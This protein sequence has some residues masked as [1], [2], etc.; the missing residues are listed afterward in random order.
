MT[1]R[2]R[3]AHAALNVAIHGITVA[4]TTTAFAETTN[5]VNNLPAQVITATRSER[6][7]SEAP[8]AIS[9]LDEQTIAEANVSNTPD[10]F[11]YTESVYI[12]KT[13]LGGGSPF[14][15]GLTG[16]QVLILID[17]VRLN[18]SFFRFGPNQYLNTIDP[19]LIERIEV[20][21]G[22]TSVLYGSDALGGT[23]NIIT[24]KRRDFTQPRDAD[25]LLATHFESAAEAGT[26]RAQAE[27][28]WNQLGVLVGATGKLYGDLRGGDGVGTQIP[29]AYDEVDADFKLNYRLSERDE[30]IVAQQYARQFDVPITSE[31]T[32]G[33]SLK[34]DYEPQ[35]RRLTYLEY[36]SAEG[37]IFDRLKLNLAYNLQREGRRTIERSTPTLQ[38]RDLTEVGT[39]SATLQLE[40]FFTDRHHFTYGF[41]YY[42][43]AYNTAAS[44]V[45]LASGASTPAA[46]LT[47]DGIEY[48]SW[49]VYL[50]D[51]LQLS[52]KLDAILG[53]RY[54]DITA[55]GSVAN[56]QL[57]FETNAVVGNVN[58]LYRLGPA[59]RLAGSLAWGFRAPSIEDFFGRVDFFR[60]IPNT[61]LQPEE[62]FSKEIGLKYDNG[63]WRGELFYFHSD[64]EGFI[65]RVTVGNQPN[66]TP[67]LQRRNTGESLIQGVEL[68]FRY[69]FTPR[70]LLAGGF[71]WTEGFSRD[72]GQ[73]LRRIPPLNGNL[74]LRY[75]PHANLW[76]EAGSTL[77]TEQ[78]RLSRGDITDPRIG[79]NGT[80]G[81]AVFDLRAGYQPLAKHQ[82][83]VS[84]ENLGD[85]RYRTHGSGIF[86]P[87]INLGLTYSI[88]F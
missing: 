13:N 1:G 44:R 28:N 65:E 9:L 67:I 80:P 50:Q 75:T 33:S 15:R 22:P 82:L 20:V 70:W 87:G 40:N 23:I 58:L 72:T 6:T 37:K 3:I 43:D 16:E 68:N 12:Q 39:Y 38:T 71:T 19:R 86:S 32:L 5:V 63:R 10:L 69:P 85:Q 31:V 51:E 14:I 48:Q 18:N 25:G 59:L 81:Y 64:Y 53:I 78:D 11:R 4:V 55:E 47:P 42:V 24:K 74:R 30:L 76:F 34:A 66:G 45:D 21:R 73:P 83:L 77:A 17:G 56:T 8:Q 29:T 41:E 79:P 49:G 36:R 26:F 35:E 27:G 7:V 61:D 88:E 60:E 2:L 62:S 52:P 57:A 84:L 54:S 46:P